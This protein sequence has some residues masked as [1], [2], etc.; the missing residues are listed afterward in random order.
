MKAVI[1]IVIA[2]RASSRNMVICSP[3]NFT[4]G[5]MIKEPT[6]LDSGVLGCD[7]VLMGVWFMTFG[8]IK[9][10]APMK[11]KVLWS[12]RISRTSYPVTKCH[13]LKT[14]ILINTAV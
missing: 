13:I 10:A 8:M 5:D 6:S 14:G 4:G 2:M 12:F 7:T 9:V 11:T 1:P 3:A